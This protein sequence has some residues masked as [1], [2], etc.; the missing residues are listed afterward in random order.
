M[1][2][3]LVLLIGVAGI[4]VLLLVLQQFVWTGDGR[5]VG[6]SEPPQPVPI[7]EES[8]A[9]L[10][11]FGAFSPIAERPLFRTDRR[12]T[13]APEV[14]QTETTFTPV[15]TSSEPSFVVIG[16]GTNENG[17]V[18][19][20]R[21]E[22]ETVRAYVGDRIDGWRIDTIN[23]ASVEVSNGETSY[24]LFIGEDTD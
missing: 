15:T 12:P 21:A 11:E 9:F 10:P 6:P 1:N 13:P 20:I 8:G 4:L 16:I 24:R 19:T 17:G 23:R 7:R 5:V 22:S 18:A 3:R 14:P 2:C